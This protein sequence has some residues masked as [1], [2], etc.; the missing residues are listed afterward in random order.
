MRGLRRKLVKYPLQHR[1]GLL[2]HFMVPESY[3]RETLR[4]KISGTNLVFFSPC[5]VLS[6]VHFDCQLAIN[7][8]KITDIR[9]DRMLPPELT[10]GKRTIAQQLPKAAFGV[11]LGFEQLS[12]SFLQWTHWLFD[13]PSPRPSP[14]TG[15]GSRSD[16]PIA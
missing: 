16:T 4:F 6:T 7:A 15:R 13:H 5:R 12:G 8:G 10:P 2:Q 14:L 3:N 9:A 1:L 11:C